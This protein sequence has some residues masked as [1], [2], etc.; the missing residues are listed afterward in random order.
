MTAGYDKDIIWVFKITLDSSTAYLATESISLTNSYDG[1]V[2]SI[3]QLDKSFEDGTISH[4]GGMSIIGAL[5]L[6]ISN[7]VSNSIFSSFFDSFYP[8]NSVYLTHRKVQVG[9][10]W[11]GATADSQITWLD[12]LRIVDYS[13]GGNIIDLQCYANSD[14]VNINIPHYKVQDNYDDG[15]SNIS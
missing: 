7:E 2:L 13:Y 12:E 1:E 11:S 4:T 6:K 10:V 8:N 14:F 15:I 9:V 5:S 3:Q